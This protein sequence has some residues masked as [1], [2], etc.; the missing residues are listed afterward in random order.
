ML[1]S[2]SRL[3]ESNSSEITTPSNEF[4]P[5]HMKV[6]LLQPTL[7]SLMF[8]KLL[9][10]MKTS[11][12]EH[13]EWILHGLFPRRGSLYSFPQEAKTDLIIDW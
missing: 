6:I 2:D 4:S 3:P 1:N 10:I 7:Q 5:F 13:Q 11:R 12:F 9:P 8:G